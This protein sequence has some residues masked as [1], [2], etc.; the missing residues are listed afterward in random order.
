MS[1]VLLFNFS[2]F[3]SY[4]IYNFLL[5][6]NI[7]ISSFIIGGIPKLWVNYDFPRTK[8]IILTFAIFII[9]TII[10]MVFNT[11]RIYLKREVFMN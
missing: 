4:W 10:V 6:A 2:P 1:L 9:G 11:I 5:V 7:V 8:K 3:S